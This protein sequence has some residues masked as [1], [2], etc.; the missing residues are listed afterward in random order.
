MTGRTGIDTAVSKKLLAGNSSLNS[1]TKSGYSCHRAFYAHL[2][3]G[4][5]QELTE[6]VKIQEAPRQK[7]LL[8]PWPLDKT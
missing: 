8:A 4:P 1:L 6:H 2:F 3:L 5:E 7:D